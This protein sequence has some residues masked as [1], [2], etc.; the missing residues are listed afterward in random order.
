[1]YQYLLPILFLVFVNLGLT[2]Q[3]FKV[4]LTSEAWSAEGNTPA[5]VEHLGTRAMHLGGADPR[6][7]G[8]NMVT[9]KDY[10]FQNGTI[11]YDI[12][13]GSISTRADILST[14]S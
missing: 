9:L 1:M 10:T 6:A 2:A 4:P 5:F 8:G 13:F 14:L 11:E 7:T 3:T 12:A